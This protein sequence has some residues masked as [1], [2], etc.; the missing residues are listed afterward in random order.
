MVLGWEN[1]TLAQ[2]DATKEINRLKAQN[3]ND[4]IVYG[5]ASF[6]SHL[7]RNQLVDELILI[8]NPVALGSGM[9]IFHEKTELKR[10]GVRS[11]SCG[12]NVLT[13]N[14]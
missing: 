12:V 4:I 2:E 1:A 9:K 10:A 3:G 6:V 7:I 14:A 8:V 11:F 5:G 13:Y